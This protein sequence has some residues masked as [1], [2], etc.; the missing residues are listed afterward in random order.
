MGNAASD[1]RNAVSVVGDGLADA[2]N[3]V[4]DGVVDAANKVGTGVV[5]AA[6][7]IS[8]VVVDGASQANKVAPEVIS[9][10]VMAFTNP[11]SVATGDPFVSGSAGARI[12][13]QQKAPSFQTS[14]CSKLRS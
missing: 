14:V 2:A 12:C 6:D 3:K 4:G 9:G 1:I 10:V 8:S 13:R 5:D 7:K 11:T